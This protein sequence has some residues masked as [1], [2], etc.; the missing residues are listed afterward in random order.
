M[1]IATGTV[2]GGK[3]EV[4][5]EFLAEGSRVMVLASEDTEPI[6][7]SADQERDLSESMDEIR[8]GEFVDG[9]ELLAEL[10][11]LAAS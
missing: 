3:I 9:H 4:P 6:R 10:R 7:L 2:I 1:K 11:A 5:E 8:R